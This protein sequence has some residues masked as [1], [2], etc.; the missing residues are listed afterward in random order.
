MIAVEKDD[1]LSTYQAEFL[2]RERAWSSG[3][4]AWLLPARKAAIARLGEIGLPTTDDEEWRFTSVAPLTRTHFRLSKGDAQGVSADQLR[5]WLL[6]DVGCRLVFINGRYAPELS[7]TARH[8]AG[9]QVG[10]LALA[11]ERESLLVRMHLAR[12]ADFHHHAFVALNTAFLDDGAYIHIAGRRVMDAPIQLLFFSTG[13][14]QARVTH[15][16]CLVLADAGSQATIIETHA[17]IDGGVYLTNCVTEIVADDNA[18]IDHYRHQ[19]EGDCAYHL[20]MLKIEQARGSQVRSHTIAL[21]GTLTRNDV[22]VELDGEGADC[23]LGGL[24]VLSGRQHV[25]NHLRVEHARPSCT[26]REL[27]KNVLSDQARAVF[28]GRIVVRR[29]AQKTDAKQTNMNL[30]LSDQARVNSRPQLEILA[31]D[32]KCTHGA[33][34]GQLDRNAIFYLRARGIGQQDARA[35]LIQAFA[36]EIINKI[37]SSALRSAIERQLWVRLPRAGW[38]AE[39]RTDAETQ[40][41]GERLW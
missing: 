22:E 34:I 31:D 16:R 9:V 24:S 38:E 3:G 40:R 15:P 37:R 20:G 6:D 2:R 27:Y 14:Q 25:D 41:R 12:H 5:P 35:M 4:Q 13:G 33:T 10:S 26:S 1:W 29:N 30:L 18:V 36:G 21:G 19:H 23:T 8:P 39:I 11:I 32:V 28:T 17:G 7:D